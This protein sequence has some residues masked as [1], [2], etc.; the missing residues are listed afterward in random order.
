MANFLTP[1]RE[2][3]EQ[4]E[5]KDA[6]IADLESQL[7]AAETAKTDAEARVQEAAESNAALDA[8]AT[9][10]AAERET[11]AARVA[12]LVTANAELAEQAAETEEKVSLAASRQLAAAGHPP[13]ALDGPGEGAPRDILQ[14]LAD[15]S[16]GERTKFYNEHRKAILAALKKG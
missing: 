1:R 8:R 16:G 9:E 6:Q 3:H 4:L 15:L 11:L 13:V 12:E 5:A 14:E 10:L 2:L 7:L